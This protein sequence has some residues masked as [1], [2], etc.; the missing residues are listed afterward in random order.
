MVSGDGDAVTRKVGRLLGL[1]DARGDM[2]PAAKAGL[3]ADL[4]AR[5]GAVLMMGDGINDA[6]ALAA[7]DVGVAVFAGRHLGR[8]AQAITLMRG[9]PH[10]LVD[11]LEFAARVR[12]KILQNLAGSF[13]YNLVS[14]P[15]A[16]GGWLS[17]LVAVGAMLLSSLSV[18]GNTL[19]M[20]RTENRRQ[21]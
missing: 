3:V 16:M 11:F 14:I 5:G 17:P 7:A 10:Q 9:D 2:R 4:Q 1:R 19:L 20:M 13:V 21:D 18:T 12:R 15:V 8:E 6:P